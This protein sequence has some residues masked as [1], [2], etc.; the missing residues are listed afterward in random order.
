MR[1]IQ[2]EN[3]FHDRV[4]NLARRQSDYDHCRPYTMVVDMDGYEFWRDLLRQADLSTLSKCEFD[5]YIGLSIVNPVDQ[6]NRRVGL[7]TAL[8]NMKLIKVTLNYIRVDSSGDIE[9][10]LNLFDHQL[11]LLL[12]HRSNRGLITGNYVLEASELYHHLYGRK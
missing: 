10:E 9:L 1:A 5:I 3:V 11:R 12:G 4:P 7:A 8:S 6:F 2:Q